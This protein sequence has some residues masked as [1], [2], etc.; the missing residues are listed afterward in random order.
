MPNWCTNRTYVFGKK[1]RVLAFHNAIQEASEKEDFRGFMHLFDPVPKVLLETTASFINV[2]NP[3]HENWVNLVA[4]GSWTQEEYD[5]RAAK[6]IAQAEEYKINIEKYGYAN[7][8]DW[9]IG[10]W[11]SKWGDCDLDFSIT[12][13]SDDTATVE[14]FYET[15][16]SP[17]TEGLERI[18]AKKKKLIFTTFYS[19]EGMGF[20]GYHKTANGE[21][22]ADQSAD[23]IPR[24]EDYYYIRDLDDEQ[25]RLISG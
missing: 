7:W 1:D 9:C 6:A 14:L 8:Y 10:T 19:E 18:S 15:A 17:I 22:L 13:H 11:G 25:E 23:F 12:Y 16:W 24:A 4:N 2:E 20:Q 3:V 5:E 21:V